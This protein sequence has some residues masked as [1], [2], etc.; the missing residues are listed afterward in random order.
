M[1]ER[2]RLVRR[3]KFLD[4]LILGEFKSILDIY[5][6]VPEPLSIRPGQ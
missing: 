2:R 1:H 3:C 6:Q 4:L 5:I